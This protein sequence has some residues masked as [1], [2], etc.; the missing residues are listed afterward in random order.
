[1]T[2]PV[3]LPSGWN[4][5]SGLSLGPQYPHLAFRGAG[6]RK[7]R[8]GR[9]HCTARGRRLK[10]HIPAQPPP[11]GCCRRPAAE[12]F[13]RQ[14]PGHLASPQGSSLLA[15]TLTP[16]GCEQQ[17]PRAPGRISRAAP[18]VPL[19]EGPTDRCGRARAP[20]AKLDV[21]QSEVRA[22]PM[23]RNYYQSE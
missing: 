22:T 1:M 11:C 5:G 8:P 21:V 6:P 17:A 23:D 12:S 20:P 16:R 18:T 19:L 4:T 7:E 15:R 2:A 13:P 3:L 9:P 14:C 10:T